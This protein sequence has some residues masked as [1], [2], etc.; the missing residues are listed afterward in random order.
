MVNFRF[1]LLR[2]STIFTLLALAAC[3][4]GGDSSATPSSDIG[5]LAYVTTEC[6]DAPEGF[7]ERQALH[8]L[9]GDHDVTVMET[10]EVGPLTALPGILTGGLCR[11][12]TLGSFGDGSISREAFQGLAVS[13]DG[14]AVVFEVSDDFSLSPQL[15]LH[16]P[17]EQKGIFFVRADGS[18]LRR[19][20]PASQLP[21]FIVING[22]INPLTSFAFSPDGR[23]ITFA[24]TGPDAAGDEAGQLITLDVGSGR[25]QQVT[26]LPPG[27]PPADLPLSTPGVSD[28]AFIDN[29]TIA[30]YTDAFGLTPAGRFAPFTVSLSD[31]TVKAAVVPVTV[32]DSVIDPRFVITG[33]KPSAITLSVRGQPENET[34]GQTFNIQE[35]FVTDGP[36]LLQLTNFQRVDTGGG[37]ALVDVDRQTVF[38]HASANPPELDGSNPSENCQ[39][40]SIDRLGANLRQLTQFSAGPRSTNG[41]FFSQRGPGCAVIDFHQDSSTGMLVFYSNC[42]PLGTNP[43]GGQ[44]FTMRPDG[45]GLRQLTHT[46][47]VAPL[48]TPG[49]TAIGELPGPIAYGPYA[50]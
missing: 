28:P 35:I 12:L 19:L 2:T 22:F 18:G 29:Q 48:L 45:G 17:P 39:I 15:P 3:G 9:H 40:F 5:T 23:L 1:L 27:I 36:N 7:S 30:F 32:P 8:I 24:D 38:F 16:L 46:R 34:P 6:R 47:G 4:G 11:S 50:P 42:D 13:P 31:G 37:E 26:H 10:P 21:F 43:H 41:C 44:V 14:A 25:R 20:G 33:D 49:G